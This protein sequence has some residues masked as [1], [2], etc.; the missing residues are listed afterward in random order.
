MVSWQSAKLQSRVRFSLRSR[1]AKMAERLGAAF[2]RQI[3]RIRVPLFAP[4]RPSCCRLHACLPGKR[5]GFDSRW[6]LFRTVGR[7]VRLLPSK[8]KDA[9]SSSARC[10]PMKHR[11]RCPGF[12]SRRAQFKSARGLC[13]MGKQSIRWPHKPETLVQIQVPLRWCSS[14]GRAAHL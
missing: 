9:D 2:P 10:L 3:T 6:S 7:E 5:S 4:A 14:I 12:V 11:W 8:Q 13:G 1:I